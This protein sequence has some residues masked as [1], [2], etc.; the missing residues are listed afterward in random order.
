MA[1]VT[2]RRV[3]TGR[4]LYATLAILILF[5]QL[6]PLQT[7]PRSWG[8]P[9][10]LLLFTLAWAAR[11]PDFVPALLV[12]GAFFLSDLLLQR[13]PG[14]WTGLVL[15]LSELLRSRAKSMR[16]LPFPLEWAFVAV[17]IAAI[18]LV[19]RATLVMVLVPVASLGLTLIQMAL[20]I[21]VY[22]VVVVISHYLLRVS[23]PAQGAV[24]EFGHRL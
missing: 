14:L 20:T 21:V 1:E 7:L 3:W 9:D 4:M 22:P 12:A 17:G 5:I 13:P 24:D 11:R 19:N 18:T 23:R 16:S 8:A 15:I 2:T 6:L 10:F